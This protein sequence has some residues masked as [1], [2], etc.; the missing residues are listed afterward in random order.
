MRMSEATRAHGLVILFSVADIASVAGIGSG[1]S[2]LS[3]VAVLA[4]MVLRRKR[5]PPERAIVAVVVLGWV[6]MLLN[7]A[8]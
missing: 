6:A 1:L 2:R 7:H 4:S 5:M 3:A 8:R